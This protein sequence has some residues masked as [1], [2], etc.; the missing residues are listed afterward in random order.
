MC[1]FFPVVFVIAACQSA[2]PPPANV[3]AAP[4]APE[5]DRVLVGAR[6]T[7]PS[8]LTVIVQE[9]HASPVVAMQVWVEAGSADEM[10]GEEGVAHMHEHLLL[11]GAG[12]VSR[13]IEGLGGEITL[14]TGYDA[15]VLS[16]VVASR[17]FDTGL[18]LAGDVLSKA[19]FDKADVERQVA[20]QRDELKRASQQPARKL[21]QALFDTVYLLHPYRRPLMGTDEQLAKISV[22]AI[23]RFYERRYTPQGTVLVVTGDVTADRVKQAATKA[24]AKYTRKSTKQERQSEPEQTEPRARTIRHDGKDSFVAFAWPI[25]AIDHRDVYALSLA[26]IILGQGDGARLPAKLQREQSLVADVYSFA[27]TPKGPGMLTAGFVAGPEKA[28]QAASALLKEV[29]RLR[30]DVVSEAELKRA[31]VVVLSD[32]YHH[33]QTAEGRA[34]KAGF[35]AA[36]VGDATFEERYY[37]EIERVTVADIKR[38]AAKY[39][40]ATKVSLVSLIPKSDAFDTAAVLAQAKTLDEQLARRED[41][42]LPAASALGVHRVKLRSGTTLLLQPDRTVPIVAFRAA[43]VGGLRYEDKSTNGLH[44]LLA[45]LLPRATERKSRND[46][47]A[48]EETLAASIE[49]FAGQNS[50]GLYGELLK[51]TANEGLEL[52]AEMLNAPKITADDLDRERALLLAEIRGREDNLASLAF[53]LFTEALYDKHPYRLR[54]KGSVDSVSALR[55]DDLLGFYRRVYTRDKLVVSIVGDFQ[56]DEMLA[57]MQRLFGAPVDKPGAPFVQP[58]T[59][60]NLKEAR[61]VER[62][63]E[64]SQAHAVIGFRGAAIGDKDRYALELLSTILSGQGGRL[65]RVLKEKQSL[66]LNVASVSIGGLEPGYFAAYVSTSP[67]KLDAAIQE[68][69]KQLTSAT[70]QPVSDEELERARHYLL[71]T[72]AIRLQ[73]ASARAASLALNELYGLGFADDATYEEQVMQV[74][75]QE[76]LRV[77]KAYVDFTKSVTAVVKPQSAP[78]AVSK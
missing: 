27:Y 1:R 38:V 13:T 68:L 72:H 47:A 19:S 7:L 57:Q 20:L 12:E 35:F 78:A 31:R 73:D 42:K 17:F 44:A 2:A 10:P 77:A 64:R 9:N 24:F 56:P 32:S 76:L 63:K 67:D 26:A 62:K 66:A 46:V 36:A 34:A 41:A 61:V 11:R 16:I 40:T 5:A 18:G 69:K 28:Q 29:D 33:K 53:D 45:R 51:A 4:K 70:E 60:E 58:L 54:P 8:G 50:F 65:A 30:S 15:T 21:S 48:L 71:G 52:A 49:G 74:T 75:A 43:F 22:D 59:E 6:F 39:L 25:P 3:A 37:T 14:R 55:A 23:N